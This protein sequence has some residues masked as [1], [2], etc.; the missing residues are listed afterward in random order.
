MS[1][2]TRAD[3]QRIRSANL[4][5]REGSLRVTDCGLG[6][7]RTADRLGKLER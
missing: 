6:G 3:R 7:R 5:G 1:S 2:S 4:V